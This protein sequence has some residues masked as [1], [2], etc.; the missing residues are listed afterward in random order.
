MLFARNV[1]IYG[2]NLH[3]FFNLYSKNINK[4]IDNECFLINLYGQY[5]LIIYNKTTSSTIHPKNN[6]KI[7]IENMKA[8]YK[9]A[10]R[11]LSPDEVSSID[12]KHMIVSQMNFIKHSEAQARQLHMGIN[13][14]TQQ[15]FINSR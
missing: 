6:L 5:S 7:Y 1:P 15:Q 4:D 2:K 9:Y 10:K 12:L 8:A 14:L 11:I 13:N 3:I